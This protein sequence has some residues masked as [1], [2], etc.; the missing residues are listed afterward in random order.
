MGFT[1]ITSPLQINKNKIKNSQ[2]NSKSNI[3]TNNSKS[4]IITNNSKSNIITNTQYSIKQNVFNPDKFS[5]PNQWNIR[6]LNR[7]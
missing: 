4:N 3:I 7:F 2:N 6:L 1:T 5:P